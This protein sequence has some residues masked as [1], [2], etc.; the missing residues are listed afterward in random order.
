MSYCR[1]ITFI[2]E[3]AC[4]AVEPRDLIGIVGVDCIR[5]CPRYHSSLQDHVRSNNSLLDSLSIGRTAQLHET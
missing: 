1:I 4:T 3:I 2:Y 5:S